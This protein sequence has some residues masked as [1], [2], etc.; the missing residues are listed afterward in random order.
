MTQSFTCFCGWG[1]KKDCNC[2]ICHEVSMQNSNIFT[3]NWKNVVGA[4]ISAVIV[5]VLAYIGNLTDIS[6]F[7]VHTVLNLSVLTAVASLLK[8]FA[9]DSTGAFLGSIPVK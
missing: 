6:Q 4:V 8:A 2:D 7:S 1:C 3:I 5:A 9:T